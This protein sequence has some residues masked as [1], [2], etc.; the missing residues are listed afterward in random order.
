MHEEL[1]VPAAELEELN[2]SIAMPIRVVRHFVGDGFEGDIDED[3]HLPTSLLGAWLSRA[4]DGETRGL[5]D[6][7]RRGPRRRR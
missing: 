1:W 2:A 7:G 6:R 5:W 4:A 3:S